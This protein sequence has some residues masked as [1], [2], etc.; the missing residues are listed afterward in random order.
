VVNSSCYLLADPM[1]QYSSCLY[2][3]IALIAVVLNANI[4]CVL[5]YCV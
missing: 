5:Y 1:S 4:F 2:L 3:A